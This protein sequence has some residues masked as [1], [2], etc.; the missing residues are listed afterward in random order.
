GPGGPSGPVPG[1]TAP[2]PAY[3]P[4][5]YGSASDATVEQSRVRSAAEYP[6][7]IDDTHP[8]PP[9]PPSGR[10]AMARWP[11]SPAAPSAA[12]RQQPAPSAAPPSA[13]EEPPSGPPAEPDGTD[14]A[15][16]SV[17]KHSSVMALGS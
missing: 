2:S 12:W 1:Y 13:A 4:P 8:L 16:A 17:A 5:G 15:G 6:G 7:G 3:G 9:V 10:P 14:G 11:G